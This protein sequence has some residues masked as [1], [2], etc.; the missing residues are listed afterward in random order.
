[1]KYGKSKVLICEIVEFVRIFW[2]QK[3]LRVLFEVQT[4]LDMKSLNLIPFIG[5][6]IRI[7]SITYNIFVRL[8]KP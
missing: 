1:M 2:K 6:H 5:I 3:Y 8:Q 7:S 4:T